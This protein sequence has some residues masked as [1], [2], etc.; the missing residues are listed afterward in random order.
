MQM[1]NLTLS[2]PNLVSGITTSFEEHIEIIVRTQ[3]L[4]R[5]G[6]H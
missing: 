2:L 6:W 4:L 3:V 5:F 1:M